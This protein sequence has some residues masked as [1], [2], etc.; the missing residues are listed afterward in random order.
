[1]RMVRVRFAPSPTGHLHIG[2]ART[3]LFNWLFARHNNGKF[4]LRIEDTDIKRSTARSVET[5]LDGLSWLGIDWDE[6]PY[7]QSKRF[8]IYRKYAEHMIRKGSAYRCY[9]TKEELEA[10]RKERLKAKKAIVYDGKCREL[11][12]KIDKPFTIRL[13]T[14]YGTTIMEDLIYGRREFDNSIIGDFILIKSDG[15]PSYNFACVIDDMMMKIS[16]VIRGDDHI[17]NTPRQLLIYKAFGATP[18]LFAH[19]PMIWGPDRKRL[20]KRH[21]A[22]SIDEY[23]KRGY[24]PDAIINYLA[25]LGWGTSD[26]QQIFTKDELISK[27]SLDRVS[28]TPAI[29]DLDKLTWMNGRYIASLDIDRLSDLLGV[30]LGGWE[31]K[32]ANRGEEWFKELV[33]VYQMRIKTLREFIKEGDFFFKDRITIDEDAQQIL[34]RSGTSQILRSAKEVLVSIEPFVIEAI[35]KGIRDLSIRLGVKAADVIHPIRAAITGR[36]SS[37]PIFD[38]IHLL[39]KERVLARLNRALKILDNRKGR[40]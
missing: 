18:P 12:K 36:S 9:C 33:S 6:G 3:A 5:I 8:H 23:R 14:P 16:H 39:G 10:R 11:A 26:S 15:S 31:R 37:P 24:L 30:Y 2:G 27:F 34:E 13:L 20:S 40:G 17:S 1:M 32:I 4:I 22:T 38:T 29:F 7:Y 35:E 21:G 28:K 25:L 19:L